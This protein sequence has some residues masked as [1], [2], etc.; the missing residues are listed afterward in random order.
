MAKAEGERSGWGP[1][2]GEIFKEAA[3]EVIG[4][5]TSGR[6]RPRRAWRGRPPGG[7]AE[8][9]VLNWTWTWEFM[10]CQRT[11]WAGGELVQQWSVW[12]E[13]LATAG[14]LVS[15]HAVTRGLRIG[16]SE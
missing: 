12:E 8:A 11:R 5:A 16:D 4:Y 2:Q 10:T 7:K 13:E 9:G 1:T 15:N 6:R 3:A 14:S